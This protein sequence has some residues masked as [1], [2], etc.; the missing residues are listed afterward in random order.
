MFAHVLLVKAPDNVLAYIPDK[1]FWLTSRIYMK[2]KMF[3]KMFWL[4]YRICS[5]MF[6]L[7]SRARRAGFLRKHENEN[8]LAY[9]PDL[10]ENVLAYIPDL[11]EHENVLENVL[12]NVP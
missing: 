7:T 5:N 1:M 2:M 8:V 9:V 10:Y 6:W 4:K 3:W 12:D 11:F